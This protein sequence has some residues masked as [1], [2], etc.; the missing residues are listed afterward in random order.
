MTPL[1]TSEEIRALPYLNQLVAHQFDCGNV[2]NQANICQVTFSDTTEISDY[3]RKT[4]FLSGNTNPPG[5]MKK[6]TTRNVPDIRDLIFNVF[7]S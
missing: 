7:L 4:F 1:T 2:N 6:A 3:G 5:P